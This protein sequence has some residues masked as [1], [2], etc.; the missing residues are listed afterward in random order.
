MNAKRWNLVCALAIVLAATLACK[1]SFTTANISSL[2]LSKEKDGS[3]NSSF[4]R[5]DKVYAMADVSNAPGKM[6]LKGRL[7]ID[8]IEGYKSGDPVPGMETTID[9]PGSSMG[10]FTFSPPSAGW[11][12]GSYKVEVSLINEDGEQKDQKTDTFSVSGE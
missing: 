10:Y 5:Q 7:L 2:K 3:T 9:L 4:G 8:N 1:F 12:K 6:K 11:P